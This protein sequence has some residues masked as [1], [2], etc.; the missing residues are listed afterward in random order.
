MY[1]CRSLCAAALIASIAGPLLAAPAAGPSG[2]L[3]IE[4]RSASC[5]VAEEFPKLEACFSPA[6]SLA[7]AQ[8]LFRASDGSPWFAVDMQREGTCFQ[9][10]LPKPKRTTK[11]IQYFVYAVDRAFTES[12]RPEDAPGRPFTPRVV[13]GKGE[14]QEDWAMGSLTTGS[15]RQ[16]VVS[17]ARDAAGRALNV[18]SALGSPAQITGFSAEGVV[19]GQPAAAVGGASGGSP[20]ATAGAAGGTSGGAAGGFPVAL[21]AGGAA[22]VVGAVAVAASSGGSDG[23]SSS[24][25]TSP[26]SNL[27]GSWGGTVASGRGITLLVTAVGG[28]CTYRWDVE[29][30]L[31][32]SGNGLNGPATAN[33]RSITCTIPELQGFIDPFVPSLET[34]TFSSTLTPPNAIVIPIQQVMMTGTYS[35]TTIDA[36]A[37]Q[38]APEGTI[39]YKLAIN[40]R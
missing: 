8:V 28:S 16:I 5:L 34:F 10:L 13:A 40:R 26:A 30:T 31:T 14:C 17:V 39:D 4:H 15:A 33:R 27:S 38:A 21:V 1:S 37:R 32:Q 25:N 6:D 18:A 12:Q 35:A 19:M 9:A 22:G 11:Q 36:T 29:M 3:A 7:R 2:S 23:D 20:T 24:G